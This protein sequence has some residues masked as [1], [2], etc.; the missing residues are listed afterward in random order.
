MV[1]A[2]KEIGPWTDI[3]ALGATMYNLLTDSIPP[4]SNRLY[5][6]GSNAFSFPSN[7][8]SSTRDLIIWMMKPDR[9]DRPQ[10]ITQ[11]LSILSNGE[12]TI[13]ERPVDIACLESDALAYFERNEIKILNQYGFFKKKNKRQ[14]TI[15]WVSCIISVILSLIA[16]AVLI[17][18]LGI[19]HLSYGGFIIYSFAVMLG[20]IP[21]LYIGPAIVALKDKKQL[22]GLAENVKKQFV[23]DYIKKHSK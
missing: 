14:A 20:F 21:G 13:V 22:N 17:Q 19:G 10:S 12:T 3:Y 18:Y 23:I 4:S 6:D 9:E 5:K 2:L 16:G 11:L 8:S 15:I 7:I 1:Q